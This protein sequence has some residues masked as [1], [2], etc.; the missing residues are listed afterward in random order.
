MNFHGTA[1]E[2]S[3]DCSRKCEFDQIIHAA[4]D[5]LIGRKKINR[6]ID[7]QT[8]D[9]LIGTQTIGKGVGTVY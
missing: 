1:M 5:R 3:P 7:T 4:K 2:I 6:L 8:I 9:G